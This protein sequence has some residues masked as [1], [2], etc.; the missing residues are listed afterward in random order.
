MDLYFCIADTA[1]TG[2][3][4]SVD[5]ADAASTRGATAYSQI[6]RVPY[7]RTKKRKGGAFV[8]RFDTAVISFTLLILNRKHRRMPQEWELKYRTYLAFGRG[9]SGGTENAECR[10]TLSTRSTKCSRCSEN[11]QNMKRTRR[12]REQSASMRISIQWCAHLKTTP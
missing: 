11:T 8:Y 3:V 5:A 2:G 9:N 6:P 4:S 1:S 7:T 10:K 12:L